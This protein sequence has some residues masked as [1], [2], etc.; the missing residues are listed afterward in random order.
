PSPHSLFPYTTLFRSV[1][2][3]RIDLA[4]MLS[5]H[6]LGDAPLFIV[7][8]VDLE[9]AMLPLDVVT[10]IGAWL[11]GL[12]S[13]EQ[14]RMRVVTRTLEGAVSGLVRKAPVVAA[15]ADDQ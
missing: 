8:E 6:G 10:P 4:R 1:D 14:A 3:V 5:H 2:E 15:A 13:D 12:A 7:P 11:H 9:D